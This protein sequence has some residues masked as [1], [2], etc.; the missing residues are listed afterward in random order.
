MWLLVLVCACDALRVPLSGRANNIV[1]LY[2]PASLQVRFARCPPPVLEDLEDLEE[3]EEDE[4]E[5]PGLP[6]SAL[7]KVP[8]P[9]IEKLEVDVAADLAAVKAL[10]KKQANKE[11]ARCVAQAFEPSKCTC[12]LQSCRA[13]R[14]RRLQGALVAAGGDT[15]SAA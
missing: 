5:E 2:V 8:P 4:E 13:I 7:P 11:R 3:D 9:V 1:T 12:L 6:L 15:E 14:V 10:S